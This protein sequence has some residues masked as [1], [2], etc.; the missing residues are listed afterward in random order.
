MTI[1]TYTY[2][3]D[4]LDESVD[5]FNHGYYPSFP[6]Y[7][8]CKMKNRMSLYRYML[9]DLKTEGLTVLDVGC[10][11]GG[12]SRV[13]KDLGFS[14]IHGCDITPANIYFAKKHFDFAHFEFC[15]AHNLSECYGTN[16]F[17]IVTNVESS[18]HY[19]NKD[20][21]FREV[22]KVLKEDGVFVYADVDAH[23]KG[24]FDTIFR[25]DITDNVRMS[26]D[27]IYE[28]TKNKESMEIVKLAKHVYDLYHVRNK[29]YIKYVCY[30]KES[31]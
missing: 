30:N 1:E 28:E 11:R 26:A 2:F 15:D 6:E 27:E 18:H 7:T 17:D 25:E 14:E 29:K 19:R 20:M 13:Y 16:Y 21:F 12:F 22:K 8:N 31:K 24:H 23:I 10:G 9:K 4:L 3:N 5:F